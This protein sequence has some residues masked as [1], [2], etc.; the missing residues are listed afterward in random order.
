MQ[1]ASLEGAYRVK[2]LGTVDVI[3]DF[4]GD[5]V[6][7]GGV[8]LDALIV[9]IRR[10]LDDQAAFIVKYEPPRQSV[11]RF[12]RLLRDQAQGAGV[13]V[14]E[15][16]RGGQRRDERLGGEEIGDVDL[17]GRDLRRANFTGCDLR[18]ANLSYCKMFGAF[19]V[20]ADLRGANLQGSDIEN[21]YTTNAIL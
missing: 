9:G 18:N 15:D 11:P 21:A 5:G 12:R 2:L 1:T 14:G 17:G 13:R 20:G 16:L 4:I 3:P 8:M 7:D 10:L 19:L 6:P